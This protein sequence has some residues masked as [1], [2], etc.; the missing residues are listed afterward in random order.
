[1]YIH[2]ILDEFG[3]VRQYH[4]LHFWWAVS[5]GQ[6]QAP[7]G[8]ATCPVLTDNRHD[9]FFDALAEGNFAVANSD[10]SASLDDS[11]WGSL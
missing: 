2:L 1:M 7:Q 6:S 5:C 10:M 3:S 4:V 11:L 8:V 9:L